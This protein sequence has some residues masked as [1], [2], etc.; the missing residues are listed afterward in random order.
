MGMFAGIDE[1]E[2][3]QKARYIEPGNYLV[4]VQAVKQGRTNQ[5]DKPYFLAE[6]KILE[7]DNP[8]F[9]EGAAVTW[10]TMLH[11][12][13]KYFLQDT[14][15][16][17]SIAT[18]SEPEEVTEDVIEFVTGD[19]QPLVGVNLRARAWTKVNENT[20]RGFTETDFTLAS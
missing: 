2:V 16:F 15:G 17:V 12:Y 20:G 11:K 19:E 18:G 8:D 1:V 13:K 3:H 7:S 4:E 5:G 6:L 9:S 14:K 10:I